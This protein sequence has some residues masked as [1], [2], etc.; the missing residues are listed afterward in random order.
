MFE[1]E[2]KERLD[3]AVAR[4]NVPEFIAGDPVQF[5]REFGELRDIET[6]AFL[7]ALLAWGK[8]SMILRDCRRLLDL[9]EWQPARFVM[10]EGWRGMDE[11]QNIHRTF[12]VKQLAYF[13]RGLREV[14]KKYPSLDAFSAANRCGDSEAP[15]WR[16]AEALRKVMYDVNEGER[17]PQCIPS[18]IETTALKRFNMALRWLVRDDGIVDMGVWKSIPKS[19]LYIPLDVHVSNISREL[20]LL[21]RKSADRKAVEQLTGVMREM[22]PEDPAVY[23]F[24]LFGLGMERTGALGI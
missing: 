17:C 24:A 5:P 21:T 18:N 19:K 11:R 22:N 13:L 1:K 3:E 14:Y 9:M 8:R 2:V 4:I 23:D 7:S 6:V 20:G 12:F 10:E 15:A 16:F